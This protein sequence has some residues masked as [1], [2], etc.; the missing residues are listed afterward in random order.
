MPDPTFEII[1]VEPAERGVAPLLHFELEITNTP[2]HE[3]V[4][5]VMLETQI[6]LEAAK[7]AYNEAEREKLFELFGMP[8]DWGR[9]LNSRKWTHVSAAI[10]SFSGQTRVTLP[11]QCT[12]DLNVASAKYLYAL[13]EGIV[14]LI[15]L[16]SGTIFYQTATGRMQVQPISWNK[17]CTYRM[18]VS[19]WKEMMEEHYPKSAWLYLE[20]EVFERLYAH[21]R[22]NGL[23]TWEQTIENLLPETDDEALVH[24]GAPDDTQSE[25][26]L[27]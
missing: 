1:S 23:V 7:R 2:A 5:S 22:E 12:Y 20:R 8:K 9:S 16:F 18:P 25:E 15:F 11:V 13:E 3:T 10:P 4:Q 21:R 6:R 17:E 14:P 27:P 26:V 24:N 19:A